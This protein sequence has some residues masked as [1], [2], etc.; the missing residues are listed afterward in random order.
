MGPA[1]SGGGGGTPTTLDDV[2]AGIDRLAD[3][4]LDLSTVVTL[5]HSAGGHLATWAASRGRFER[6][7]DG[8]DVTAVVSQAGVLDLRAAYDEGLGSGAGRGVPG[9][10]PRTRRRPGGPAAAGPARRTGLCACTAA[11]TTSCD[12][13]VPRLRRGRHRRGRPGRVG[14]GRGRPLHRHRHRLRRLEAH[15]RDPRLPR[16]TTAELGD[17]PL[18]VRAGPRRGARRW[19]A[20]RWRRATGRCVRR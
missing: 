8:V 5:G 11:P 12:Q 9:P 7:V 13:P 19:R 20:R 18:G 6:W 17:Y 15:P 4:D 16:L 10:R 14:R 2:A 1:A 3:L